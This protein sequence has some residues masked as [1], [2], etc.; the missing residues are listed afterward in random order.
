MKKL[1]MF[2]GLMI[3]LSL[4]VGCGK[5]DTPPPPP[6]L[7]GVDLPIGQAAAGYTYAG[8][9]WADPA[10]TFEIVNPES[11]YFELGIGESGQL[12]LSIVDIGPNDWILRFGYA[13]VCDEPP[14]TADETRWE[15][16][17]FIG[18]VYD[19][20][21]LKGANATAEI[22][23]AREDYNFGENYVIAYV[24]K[25]ISG[26]WD[27]N[28]DGQVDGS[29]ENQYML[30]PF[31]LYYKC[32]ETDGGR[33]LGMPGT[34]EG[35]DDDFNIYSE[36]ADECTS[37][38]SLKEYYC[39][40]PMDSEGECS[41]GQS[42]TI[43]LPDW[44]GGGSNSYCMPAGT[45][46]DCRYC[47][48]NPA[49][50]CT[51]SEDCDF[52]VEKEC[53]YNE[54][55]MDGACVD[56][57]FFNEDSPSKDNPAGAD[58][59][60]VTDKIQLSATEE[61]DWTIG[62]SYDILFSRFQFGDDMYDFDETEAR[63]FAH[64]TVNYGN[65]GSIGSCQVISSVG[66]YTI[67]GCGGNWYHSCTTDADCKR[68]SRVGIP[69]QNDGDCSMEE[70]FPGGWI[71]GS[72]SKTFTFDPYPLSW[73]IEGEIEEVG[74]NFGPNSL[75]VYG[76]DKNGP[77]NCHS[78]KWTKKDVK[79]IPPCIDDDALDTSTRGTSYGMY[80]DSGLVES[81]GVEDECISTTPQA[82]KVREYA[83]TTD[84]DGYVYLDDIE[85]D[86]TIDEICF[87]GACELYVP[88]P[89]PPTI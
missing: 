53:D 1:W 5:E 43:D 3:I 39:N 89:G 80:L 42:I 56:L 60:N 36:T 47:S 62:T 51:S 65:C 23:I 15:Q 9:G 64:G 13:A 71:I 55:C 79:I 45:Y 17:E 27:C 86:C 57:P 76:C 61:V 66:G 59:V 22:E 75:L 44:L 31:D 58:K 88:P 10:G 34:I 78:N 87:L 6:D 24:C 69:C 63:E 38:T 11:G 7:P 40:M 49:V 84:E 81:E 25:K 77:W 46:P 52:E 35:V 21:W 41:V 8:S 4:I 37:E 2:L 72:G 48:N 33:E 83:C 26:G 14:C 68:C 70:G 73:L 16:F 30:L 74:L 50:S 19:Q 82:S 67:K 29:G 85:V 54:I 18:Q 28:N 12:D 20:Y 32:A